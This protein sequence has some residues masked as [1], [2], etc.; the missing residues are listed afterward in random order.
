MK[1]DE[2]TNKDI[3]K[4]A[5]LLSARGFIC[6]T[7]GNIAIKVKPEN[8]NDSVIH[9][10]RK[11]I[12]LTEMTE[13]D[14]AVLTADTSELLRGKNAP[15]VGYQLNRE[16][17]RHRSDINAVIHLH[18]DEV[19]AY[20]SLE[21]N[22]EFRYISDDTALV[23][24]KPIY[25]CERHVNVEKDASHIKDFIANTN[26]FIMPNHGVTVL[27]RHVSEAYNRLTSFV[28][29]MRRINQAVLLSNASGKEVR[30]ISDSERDEMHEWGDETIYGNTK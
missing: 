8:S 7:L 17:F 25:V 26:C 15:S 24:G 3:L 30:W 1:I 28:A 2:A 29:E 14:I 23:M 21:G 10:K 6:N 19:I 18:I 5:S 27:G 9:T 12:S 4:Y 16:I 11:G 13:D 20:F 22:K